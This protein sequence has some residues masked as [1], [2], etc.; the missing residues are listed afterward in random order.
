MDILLGRKDIRVESRD[1]KDKLLNIFDFN[2]PS[3]I[4][5]RS[6]KI[7]YKNGKFENIF[8]NKNKYN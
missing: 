8:K 7:I 3:Q 6:E 2:I 4:I 1:K 5:Y